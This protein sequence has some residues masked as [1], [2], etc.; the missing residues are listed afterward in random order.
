MID[1]IVQRFSD[2]S[3]LQSYDS[4]Q[5]IAAQCYTRSIYV[6]FT[7][8][9][10]IG[11][12]GEISK[13]HNMWTKNEKWKNKRERTLH[14][15]WNILAFWYNSKIHSLTHSSHTQH[16]HCFSGV[17][18]EISRNKTHYAQHTTHHT[19]CDV[20]NDKCKGE[21]LLPHPQGPPCVWDHVKIHTAT[22]STTHKHKQTLFWI[23]EK[24]KV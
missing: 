16:T 9:E 19:H 17:F 22:W 24:L 11:F 2:W 23:P 1:V 8:G 3:V 5:P 13:S 20:K 12:F 15:M 18:S 7:C 6:E 14:L 10:V 21:R 4:L